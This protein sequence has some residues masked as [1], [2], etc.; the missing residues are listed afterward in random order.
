MAKAFR[1][2]GV[3]MP[4]KSCATTIPEELSFSCNDPANRA[5]VF[6]GAA[7]GAKKQWDA[8]YQA[9]VKSL[10]GVR[11]KL[12]SEADEMGCPEWELVAAFIKGRWS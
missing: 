10:K 7:I 8:V 4:T 2:K 6:E 12:S 5:N 9:V 11:F 3:G 1:T